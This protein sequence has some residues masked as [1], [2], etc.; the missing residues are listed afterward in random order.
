MIEP[1]KLT[2]GK[3]ILFLTKDPEL[4]RRQIRGELDLRMEDLRVEDLLD[5]IN[6][7]VMTPAWVCFDYEPRKIAE[8]AYAGLIVDG[9]RL[10]PEGA[11][12]GG[13]FEIVVSG[14]GKGTGS[15]RE[16]A[17]QAEKYSGVRLA[18]AASFAPIHGRN[19]INQ[20]VLMGDHAMLSRIQNGETIPVSEFCE[21][22]DPVTAKI[23]EMGGLFAFTK[24]LQA[25]KVSVPAPA[26]AERPLT[27]CEKIIASHLVER[28]SGH[29]TPGDAV[30]VKVD[31]GY[32]HEFT[33]AQVHVFLQE[34]YGDDYTVSNPKKFAV[35]EDHL[36]YA[37]EVER[38]KKFLPKI[39][40]LRDMQRTFADHTGVLSFNAV[41]GRS[42][43]IC[44]QLAR[45][46]IVEPGDFI[47]AT[48]SHTC[49]GGGS[50]AYTYGV[51]TTEYAALCQSGVTSVTVPESIR[52]ELTGELRPGATAKDVML[53]ILMTYAKGDDRKTINRCMEFGGP[54]LFTLSVDE[55]ATL[56]NMATECS[57][58]SGICE[59]DEKTVEWI[60]A[61]RPDL[62]AD[63]I[64]AKIVTPDAGATYDGGVHSI[65]LS[66]IEPMV[67][68][69]GDP[70]R[71]IPSD[72]TNGALISTLERV[73]I[74]IAYGGSCTAGKEHDLDFYAQVMQ[75]A[76]TA[77]K[78]VAEHVRF[79][80]QFGSED[81]A[82]Y[83]EAKGYLD[84]FERTGVTVIPPGCGACIGCGPG[85]SDT[86]EQVSISAINRN[87]KGRSGPGRLYLAS[88]L[89]VA[90]SA[91]TGYIAAYREGM[92]G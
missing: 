85:V 23:I 36:I 38:F 28:G 4:I 3:R 56:A 65:D 92:F 39:Q 80:I 55:R 78:R 26:T 74:D 41:E 71:G 62:S 15:S 40:V 7:D 67:A 66:S 43:G 20:G 90:A 70:D 79:Y 84:V 21:G 30:L 61:R 31:G 88:P 52:F 12:A 63:A 1:F 54:G 50:N 19:N 53:Y 47:Q 76:L 9:E 5:D 75:E 45:E 89:S 14:Q 25:G 48:D 60:A 81:V 35:F 77:G 17:V 37:G 64:R 18:V 86:T 58:R 32:S 16:T 29:V 57:A 6:T 46:K 72:P 83:A 42:P 82:S 11:L 51:G 69:P 22:H 13:N 87:F 73:K 68:D 27:M 44:H 33:T 24:A 49:M 91:V 10:I 8:N 34:A 59:A 2:P